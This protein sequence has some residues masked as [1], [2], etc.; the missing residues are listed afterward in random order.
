MRV[1]I[2]PFIA[3]L[4]EAKLLFNH[5]EGML[6]P[7]P[8]SGLLSVSRPIFFREFAAIVAFLVDQDACFGRGFGDDVLLVQGRLERMNRG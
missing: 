1:F 5:T 2:E 8:D 6:D 4:P 7:G 3:Y